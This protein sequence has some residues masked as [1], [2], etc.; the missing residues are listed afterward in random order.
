MVSGKNLAIVI[1]TPIIVRK[2]NHR[3]SYCDSRINSL[4]NTL[5]RATL[6]NITP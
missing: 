6:L 1:A 2:N 4:P 5:F 3:K